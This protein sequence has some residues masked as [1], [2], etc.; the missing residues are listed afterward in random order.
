MPLPLFGPHNIQQATASLDYCTANDKSGMDYYDVCFLPY[1]TKL[2][3]LY[4]L[5]FFSDQL[6][7]FQLLKKSSTDAG[8]PGVP[9][10]LPQV[11]YI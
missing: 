9:V 11:L 8:N 10:L 7:V 1:T 2:W 4:L 5:M 6:W 3:I